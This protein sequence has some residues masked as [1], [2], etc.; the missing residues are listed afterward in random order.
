[1]CEKVSTII[2]IESFQLGTI[3]VTG[4]RKVCFIHLLSIH[5]L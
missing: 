1:M 2:G 4:V 3:V 5:L